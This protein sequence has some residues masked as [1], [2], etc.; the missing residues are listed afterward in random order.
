MVFTSRFRIAYDAGHDAPAAD[1]PARFRRRPAPRAGPGQR[2]QHRHRRHHRRRHLLHADE[3][4][5]YRRQR[6]PRAVDVG[7]GWRR[8][9]PRGTHLRRARRHVRPHRRTVRDPARLVRRPRRV[10]LRLL[11]RDR[12]RRGRC[13]NHLHGMRGE[14]GGA[15]GRQ[16]SVRG[17]RGRYRGRAD[18]AARRREHHR[19]ALGG[20]DPE[21]HRVRQG[22]GAVADRVAC[23]VCRPARRGR[24]GAPGSGPR[25]EAVG[26]APVLPVSCRRCSRTGAGSTC[27]GSAGK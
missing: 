19:R 25:G 20:S 14:P 23:G 21:R 2:H 12:H 3:R 16:C 15:R 22:G 9:P 13:R 18:R 24:T 4:R 7:R 11:Q 10:L 1:A 27:C 17:G 8:G 5:A 6:T 26:C